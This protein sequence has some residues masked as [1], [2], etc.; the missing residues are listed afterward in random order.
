QQIPAK[1][2][3]DDVQD[4]VNP[5]DM[6]DYNDDGTVS[7]NPEYLKKQGAE[8]ALKALAASGVGERYWHVTA[9][10]LATT[11][12]LTRVL[13]GL[14]QW[15]RLRARGH[16]LILTGGLGTGKTQAAVLV[17]K[18]ALSRGCTARLEKL[19]Q[20][21]SKQRHEPARAIQEL[22]SGDRLIMPT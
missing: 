1:P 13:S 18:Y 19:R 20:M 10:A 11:Q 12:A 21:L 16:N 5:E 15:D 2:L 3:T 8:R 14:G 9:D 4:E 22:L 6:W 7:L 17:L